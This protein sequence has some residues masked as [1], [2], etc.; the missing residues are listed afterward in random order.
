MRDALDDHIA[1]ITDRVDRMAETDD[2]FARLEA[3][4]DVSLG[5]IGIGIA[6]LDLQ[7]HFVGTAVLGSAQRT[8]GTADG[9]VDI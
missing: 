7:R 3:A 5:G 6:L 2:H 8:D 1:R 4:Q 9:R